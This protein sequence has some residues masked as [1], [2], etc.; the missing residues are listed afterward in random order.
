MRKRKWLSPLLAAALVAAQIATAVPATAFAA[1]TEIA[2]EDAAQ[3]RA[4]VE[5][6]RQ[7]KSSTS[8]DNGANAAILVNTNEGTEG[9]EAG[10]FSFVMKTGGSQA[11]TRFNVGPYITDNTHYM[12][13]GYN[14]TGW[15]YEYKGAGNDYPTINNLPT[16]PEAGQE[17]PITIKWD[18]TDYAVTAGENTVEFQI[19]QE[20]YDGLK[21]GKLGF[22]I[23]SWNQKEI[24]DIYFKDVVIKDGEGNVIAE[25]GTDTWELQTADRGEVYNEEVRVARVTV[26]GRVV[27]EEGAPV[28]D[29]E[30]ALGTN[31][32]QT[33]AEGVY[34]FEDIAGGSYTISVS[35]S[36]FQAG[37]ADITV[38][39]EDI[40]VD[41]IVLSKGASVDFEGDDT[42]SSD[43]MEVAISDTFPQV[44]GYTMKGGEVDGRK[45]YG[46]TQ[47]LTQL[48]VNNV[49]VTPEV[50]YTK[51]SESR[52]VYTM[53]I[54]EQDISAT[55]TAALEVKDNTLSFDI[56]KIDA[57]AGTFLTVEIPNHNLVT[58]KANQ[59]GA[60]FAGANM[61][62]NTTVSGDT[63]SS[64]SAQSDGKRGY[65]YAFVSTDEL[66]AG[67]WSNS[68]NNVTADWQ[69]VTA[70]TSTVDGVKETGLS[71]TY[72]TYQKSAEHRIENKDYEMPSTKIVI[73]GDENDD[74]VIDW[75]DGAV[76]YRSIMN[77]PVGAEL[78]PDRV[79]IRIAMNFNSHAQNPFLMTYDN[80]QKV[81]LNTDGLGQS[82]LLKGYGSEGHDSGH[83]NYADVGRRIGGVEEM[84][85]LLAQGKEIG[86]TFGIHV[87]ASETY[88]ESKYFETD[89]LKKSAD[90]TLSYGWNWL[91]QGVNIDADYDLRHGREQRFV[92]LWEALGGE[93]NDLDFIYVDVWGNGQSGDNGTWASRQ[94]AK[95][96]TQTCGW[97]LAGEWGHANEYDSTFQ[98]WAA[99]LTYGGATSK[100][101]NSYITRFIRNHQKDS[102]VGDYPSYGGAAVEPLL[103]GYDMKDFEGWQGR[104]DYKAY[105]QNLF[106]DNLATKFLQHYLVM[107]WENGEPTTVGGASW[108][109][110]KRITL[111]DEAKENTVVVERKSTDG[112][113]ADYR[114]RNMY[115]NGRQIMD[116]ETYLIPWFWDFNGNEL[117]DKDQKLYH[118]NQQGGTTTWELP[119]GWEGAHIYELTETGN[120]ECDD[121]AVINGNQ[122]TI[123][124]EASVPYVLH[125]ADYGEGIKIEELAWSKGAHIVDTGF[126][127]NTLQWWDIKGESAEII[128]S[129][130][131]NMMLSVGSEDGE[132]SLTQTVTD[133][134]PG[135]GY[136][137]YVGVDNRSDAKAYIEVSVD[138]EVI[139]NYT[140]RSIARNYLQSYAHNT[141]NATV[142]GGGSYFQNM[143]VFFTAPEEGREVTLTLRREA[144]EGKTYFDDVRIVNNMFG[145]TETDNQFNPFESENKLYQTFEAVP[146]GLFPFVIGNAEGVTDNRTHL[147][148]KHEP[149][150]QAGWY[151]VKKLDDVLD[152]DWS[153]KTNGLS[154]YNNLIY[155][156]IP[157]NYRFEEG[158]TYHISF[159]YEMGS[160]NTYA[161]AVGNGEYSRN[162]IELYELQATDLENAE[163][164]TFTFRLTGEPGNQS[165]IGIYSTNTPADT[166]GTGGGAADFGGY[167]DFILDNLV[168]E[169]SAAHKTELDELVNAN[170]GRY[171]VN[172]SADSWAEFTKAMEE[173]EKVLDD[174]SA[175]QETVDNTTAALEKAVEGLEVIAVTLSG[176]VKDEAGTAVPDVEISAD[177]GVKTTTDGN[178]HYVLPG[179]ALGERRITAESSVF[180][181]N[182][183]TLTASEEELEP[184]LDFTMKTE[185]TRVEGTVTAVGEPEEGVT[186]TLGDQTATTDADGFYAFEEVVTK[187]Y[188]MT[189]EKEGYDSVTKDVTVAKGDKTVVDTMLPPLTRDEADYSNDYEDGVKTWDNLSGNT[190]S[191]T[192]AVQNGETKIIFPGG[193]TNVYE[194]EAPTFKNGCVEMDLR[195]ERDGI[196]IGILL[197]A[198][199][200]NN[201]VYVGVG[202]SKNQYF[203]EYWGKSGNSWSSMY[204]G[205]SF[206]AGRTMHL[207]A[208]I[209]DN[210]VTLWVN[211]TEVFSNVMD[212]MPMDAGWIGLNTRNSHTVY[213]DNVEVTSYD[214]PTGELRN[215]AGRV[216]DGNNTAIENAKVELLSTNGEELKSTTTDALGN[217][218]FKNVVTGEYLVRVTAGEI[219][220]EIPLTVVNDGTDY[221]V[222]D[223][224]VM[225]EQGDKTDLQ[226]LIDYAYTQKEQDD[227]QYVVPAVKE[228]FEARLAEAE[229]VIAKEYASQ[230]EIDAA[231]DALLDMVHKLG[232]TGNSENLKVLADAVKG[233]QLEGVYTDETVK[234]VQ[235]ALAA[236]E[237]VLANENALQEEIDAARDALQ[238]AVD[239]LEKIP[240]D[241]SRLQKLVDD[242]AEYEGRIDEF[243]PATAEPF[244]AALEGARAVLADEGAVQAEA[245]SAYAALQ[246]AIFGLREIPDKD[247]LEDLIKEAEGMDLSGYTAE[248]AAAFRA[249]LASAKAV[250]ADPN[251]EKDDVDNAVSGLQA[252][253]DGLEKTTV[254]PGDGEKPGSGGQDSDKNDGSKNN[255]SVKTGD[256][257]PI[258]LYAVLVILAA[259]AAALVI[260]MIRR[261][262]RR[263]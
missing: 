67:L 145:E 41:D 141:N 57:E 127:S 4:V 185:M 218:K 1:G 37:S 240:V 50:E 217:Y 156:T 2:D 202:D 256:N 82:I 238:A 124:A 83:L 203:S 62:N 112:A 204:T 66:S 65:M 259:G 117:A 187:A 163:P 61:S 74:D 100:G 167:K 154:G 247:K 137:A 48:K 194:T 72:W 257:A 111:Q 52:A 243:T 109:P 213:V 226:A 164:Q 126:N 86:A 23:G 198:Q 147:S 223:K 69:R 35:K 195:S 79:A 260:V 136:A 105:I 42:I 34:T 151:G 94:L 5:T 208:E 168:I 148:E 73:T 258:V 25:N 53:K 63:Y 95:E 212:G 220:K 88:P 92:D 76:A 197:R 199:D 49:L 262:Q 17:M 21:T 179:V 201:R 40:T 241:K 170:S 7:F 248:T 27:D 189:F 177:N 138:G 85:K 234:A 180:S 47:E 125:K 115:F 68:E 150:T 261:R 200:M 219:V 169:K 56:T 38:E 75:Q 244:K 123:T 246:N 89:R 70:V 78:V 232:Y 193:H 107:K 19:P 140:E 230:E 172:Y 129:A 51:E 254:K 142:A 162:N 121:I 58:V 190:S 120:V 233:M 14:A 158:E 210:R 229:A 144:G 216:V 16:P 128:R 250:M 155:Q 77:N 184:V 224:A 84:K 114:H 31:V 28:A 166:Q 64:I 131:N 176:S 116:G 103:G 98:H 249:A 181:T 8:N 6:W 119:E 207:K 130:A 135:K 43:Q 33:D 182:T 24:S 206:D 205:D 215:V 157:Q 101:I 183:Q 231:Y 242:A 102:W 110:E 81:Y 9:M 10:E 118:W 175:S 29:A 225:A 44:V 104:N 46:Q 237:K 12:T 11:T 214:L 159:Q 228:L 165:W 36:G 97:R 227:Y 253:I 196:R 122:I 90:G 152:G 139:S 106:D 245:D 22:R 133:L 263:K 108:T 15:F 59:T 91:D 149:Y 252:A 239:G 60:Y 3:Q 174:A 132:V 146:Q 160:E 96:I 80:A 71:S 171:E 39:E 178:G 143:Y 54:D 188:T 173:A 45:F 222:V 99:D 235:D 93:D 20:A 251:A 26:T 18:G 191:T 221:T 87:N 32:T 161:F 192:I 134:V 55:V 13:I 30:A 113:S 209:V 255:S 186:V 236:A 153:V 211:G